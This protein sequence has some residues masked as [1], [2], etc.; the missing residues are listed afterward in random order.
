MIEESLAN[1]EAARCFEAIDPRTVR[2]MLILFGATGLCPDAASGPTRS[3]I[4]SIGIIDRIGLEED[5]DRPKISIRHTSKRIFERLRVC[6][7]ALR[8]RSPL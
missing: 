3:S 6:C 2:K 8:A 7:T 4:R 5:K 1:V